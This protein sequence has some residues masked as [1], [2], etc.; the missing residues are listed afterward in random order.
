[1]AWFLGNAEAFQLWKLQNIKF[2]IEDQI[3]VFVDTPH[4]IWNPSFIYQ[5][6]IIA[7][8]TSYGQ[9]GGVYPSLEL[10]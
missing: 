7:E 1:M 2:F 4:H 5:I 10:F 6:L 9:V 3:I 8:M